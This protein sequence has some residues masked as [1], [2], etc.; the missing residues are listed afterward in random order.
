MNDEARREEAAAVMRQADCLYT[1]AEVEAAFDRMATAIN[2]DLRGGD[3]L[4]ICVMNGGLVASGILLPRLDVQLRVDY[5][6]AS[7]YR[8]RTTGDQLH[9]KVEPAQSLAGKD[10]LI[11]DD[12]LDEGYTLDAIIRYCRQHS[13]AS[14]RA[15]V[16]VRKE[17]GR[18]VRPP[19]DYIG[20]SVP[21]RYVF[22]Y[23]MDYKGYWRN[24]PGIYA[25][26]E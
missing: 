13:P 15:A 12:I 11:I 5:L 19:V 20:L 26:A 23:G 9:W 4:L 6:H 7:R 3:V 21:D 10:L 14:V 18:G 17:H 24:A 16:L 8:E 22:G 25:V 1:K 2:R